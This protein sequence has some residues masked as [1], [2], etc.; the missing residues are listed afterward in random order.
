MAGAGLAVRRQGWE[1]PD[2]HCDE[3]RLEQNGLP[4]RAAANKYSPPCRVQGLPVF[5]ETLE[6]LDAAEIS[7]RIVVLAGALTQGDVTPRGSVVY[8][9]EAHRRLNDRLDAARPAAMIAVAM[10]TGSVRR[11]FTDPHLT[12]PSVT[13]P[14]EVGAQ[15][16][17]HRDAPVSL[18]IDSRSEPGSGYTVIG[19]IPGSAETR[20]VLSAHY[21]T[22]LDTPGAID[23]AS[24]VAA[25]L[26]LAEILGQRPHSCSL[27]F[28]AFGAEEC[29]WYSL[30]AY[31]APY[32]LQP[33]PAQWGRDVGEVSPAWLPIVANINMDGIGDLLGPT[34]VCVIAGSPA[35]QDRVE[36]IRGLRHPAI[37][38]TAPWPA[39]D[40]HMFYSHGVPAIALNCTGI[41]GYINH[42]PEDSLEWVSAERLASA[43]RFVEELVEALHEATPE[44][45][46]P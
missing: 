14:A 9:P 35:L 1:C 6:Q 10:R 41:A 29:G 17:R 40:H 42:E 30:D 23:N 27:E 43:V 36:E 20:L 45:V 3:T 33:I 19:E 37:I 4:L 13:V 2:W 44:W 39:S 18:S 21:D 12:I 22:V 7:G 28:A 11:V 16:L 25:L 38:R 32:G 31:L 34:N 26:A 24:G 46:R 15:L 5:A 8:Y